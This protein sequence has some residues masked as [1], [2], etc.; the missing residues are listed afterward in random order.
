MT[1]RAIA[2]IGWVKFKECG[3]LLNS[4]S[5]SI[6][7]KGMVYWSCVRLAMLYIYGSETWCLKENEMAVLRRTER[8]MV[9]AMCGA[10]LM[11]KKRTEDLMEM[12]GL[13]ETVVQMVKAN[14]V[15]WYGHVLW[16]DDGHVLGKALE[17]EVK[18]KR[19]RGRPKKTWKMQVE[20]D[21]KSVGLEKE[22]V[23]NRARSGEWALERLLLEWGKYGHPHL[24]G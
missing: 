16:R 7:M 15:R 1:V 11:E 19:K 12:L 13:K 18:G 17:F 9:R 14:G 2:R 5:F 10:K 23:L 22:D 4:K 6:K 3:E 8:A 24:R 21:S 20:K